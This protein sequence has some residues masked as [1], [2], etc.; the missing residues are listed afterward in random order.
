MASRQ[1]S[2]CRSSQRSER[3]MTI[4]SANF[5]FSTSCMQELP[6]PLS[7]GK[8]LLLS[9]LKPPGPGTSGEQSRYPAPF[10]SV[11]VQAQNKPETC[12]VP[13]LES[14][15]ALQSSHLIVRR[16]MMRCI[17]LVKSWLEHSSYN[18]TPANGKFEASNH[19]RH[20]S[21][22][23]QFNCRTPLSY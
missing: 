7:K 11:S 3:T 10:P 12:W 2:L 15:T 21:S 22:F 1:T 19:M 5:L 17:Y 23:Y 16:N 13:M 9:I 14:L 8:R 4:V 20:G 18:K 6:P